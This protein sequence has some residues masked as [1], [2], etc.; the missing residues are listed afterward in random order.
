MASSTRCRLSV[1]NTTLLS[2][3]AL[4][5]LQA[6]GQKWLRTSRHRLLRQPDNSRSFVLTYTHTALWSFPPLLSIPVSS[7]HKP[8]PFGDEEAKERHFPKCDSFSFGQ[9]RNIFAILRAN[10]KSKER[11]KWNQFTNHT[12]WQITL[13]QEPG[14]LRKQIWIASVI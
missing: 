9:L 11:K 10:I 14:W 4:G 5:S 2:S 8:L 3:A 6:R 1:L 7:T 13:S 12:H